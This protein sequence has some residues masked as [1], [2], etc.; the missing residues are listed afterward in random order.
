MGSITGA[1]IGA[2]VTSSVLSMGELAGA[3][4]LKSS[5]GAPTTATKPSIAPTTVSALETV[6]AAFVR[7]V[8]TD[9]AV[10]EVATVN[11]IFTVDVDP[12]LRCTEASPSRRLRLTVT[13]STALITTASSS[14]PRARAV[15]FTNAALNSSNEPSSTVT[16]DIS[17]RIM[18]MI[19]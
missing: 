4:V 1:G 12:S 9:V 10:A 8:M 17:C 5:T 15:A 3:A 13:R 16:P 2:S 19:R 14:T 18:H 11:E 7:E 6:G